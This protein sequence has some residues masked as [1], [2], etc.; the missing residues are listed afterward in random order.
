MAGA[1]FRALRHKNFRLFFGGQLV[2]LVGT[3]MQNVAQSWLV[4]RL[5]GSPLLL[6]LVGFANQAPIFFLA[7]VGGAIA[8]RRARRDLLVVTQTISML[9]AFALAT[10]TL[11]GVVRPWEVF[12]LAASLGVVNA[13]DIP[14]RQA[15]VVEMVGKEDLP[16]AIALNSSM[17]NGA[18]IVGPSVAGLLVAAIGEG[19]CFFANAVSFVAVIGA[20]MAIRVPRR[21]IPAATSRPFAHAAEGFQFVWRTTPVRA[22][23]LLLG[24]TSV[25]GMPYAVLMPIFADRVLHA[26]PRGLGTLMGA[27]GVGA[28]AGALALASRESVRG[29]GRWVATSAATFGIALVIFSQSRRLEL[30]ELLLVPVGAGMMVQ[31]AA[32]NTLVQTMTP[33]HLRGRVMAVYAMTFMGMAP[34]GALLAGAAAARLGAPVT[35]ALGGAIAMAAAAVFTTRLPAL[36]AK[37]HQAEAT[38]SDRPRP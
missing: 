1:T 32:S 11:S 14:T 16:N 8:D 7:T 26:G 37:V 24:V 12:A 27:S 17:F 6:G 13:F 21:E 31:M 19:W 15:F 20:L 25:T 2:S 5:T 9:L 28:L 38:A 3:W 36:R 35:V 18:R 23:L 34:L 29:L 22:I 10:L 4:Y 33:D 30:S